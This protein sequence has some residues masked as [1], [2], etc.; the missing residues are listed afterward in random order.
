MQK[1]LIKVNPADNV[2]VALT[3]LVQNEQIVFEGTTVSPTTDVKAKHKIAE[4]D[5]AIGDA[6]I[7]YGVLV[8]KAA[9]H[10]KK[11]EVITTENV[12]HQSEKVFG[13]NGSLGWTPPNVDRWKNK[14]TRPSFSENGRVAS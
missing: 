10:V 3:D 11:G 7:M 5:F 4:I 9:K 1:K 2:I 13:K 14:T 12:K 6:I 8:G